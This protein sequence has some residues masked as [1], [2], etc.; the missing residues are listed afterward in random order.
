MYGKIT[1]IAGAVTFAASLFGLMGSFAEKADAAPWAIMFAAGLIVMALARVIDCLAAIANAIKSA[2][3]S[4]FRPSQ[5]AAASPVRQ[6]H[7]KRSAN[8]R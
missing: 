3:V 7:E 6:S 1:F 4:F 8:N 2:K 5:A